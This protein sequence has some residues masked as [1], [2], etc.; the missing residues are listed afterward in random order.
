ML[1]SCLPAQSAPSGTVPFVLDG[2]RVYAH[3]QFILP[4]GKPRAALVFVDLG[5]PAVILSRALYEELDTGSTKSLRIGI[6]E[7][8][9]SVESANVTSDDWVAFSLGENRNV[10]GVLPAGVLLNYQ[11]RFDYARQT[12]TIAPPATL[13][14]AGTAI[15]FKLNSETGLIAVEA[16]IDGQTYPITI[17]NGSGYSW[18][19]RTTAQDWFARHPDWQRGTGAVGPSNMRMADDGIESAGALLRIPRIK[20][21]SLDVEQ[22]GALAIASDNE[23]HDFMD[24]YSTKN[25]VSVI[26][27]LGGNVLRHFRITI[28][29]PNKMSY[30]EQQSALDSHDLDYVGLTLLS[31]RGE[32]YVAGI[33]QRDGLPA[34]KGVQVGDK[35]VRIGVLKTHG[36][37]REAIFGA[38]HGKPGEMRSLLL[39]RQGSRIQVRASV[40]GF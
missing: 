16:N 33:A 3:V 30:W 5:S 37:S 31:R 22:V 21:G 28:D 1:L 19:R 40:T 34:V 2:N 6:G 18:I 13:Q 27:W 29:Y 17:D 36:A 10:E 7:L 14:P 38:M 20:L 11:V 39:E 32:Y 24:W 8:A 26:G 4:N 23:G 12:M 35:L 15:P 25:A 9:V